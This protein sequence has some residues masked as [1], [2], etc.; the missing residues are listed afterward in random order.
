MR[1][2]L[3]AA[4][5]AADNTC[6]SADPE[7]ATDKMESTDMDEVPHPADD[8][9]EDVLEVTRRKVI[10]APLFSLLMKCLSMCQQNPPPCSSILP[11]LWGNMAL[12][13]LSR[14]RS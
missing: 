9:M 10:K 5:T 13:G 3:R 7:P 6:N 2:L 11:F 4:T 14:F 8:A 12:L 1:T